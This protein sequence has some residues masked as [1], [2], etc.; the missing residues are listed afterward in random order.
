[1]ETDLLED[2]SVPKSDTSIIR[3]SATDEEEFSATNW[4]RE[5]E[6]EFLKT[7]NYFVRLEWNFYLNGFFWL[8]L[9]LGHIPM[10]SLHIDNR[11]GP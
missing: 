9:G 10:K 8:A 6:R 4:L 3:G 2:R 7:I 1:M 5:L 11:I